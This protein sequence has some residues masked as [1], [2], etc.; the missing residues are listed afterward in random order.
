M[1]SGQFNFISSLPWSHSF[2]YIFITM[3]K[4]INDLKLYYYNQFYDKENDKWNRSG[5]ASGTM[6]FS[7]FLTG[8]NS[9]YRSIIDKIRQTVYHSPEYDELKHKIPYVWCGGTSDTTRTRQ[10]DV[11]EI[12]NI[13][14]IDIDRQDNVKLFDDNGLEVLRYELLHSAPC[15]FYSG[16]SCGGYGLVLYALVK[17]ITINNQHDVFNYFYDKFEKAGIIIDNNASDLVTRLRLI[18]YDPDAEYISD[19][20][21]F[22]CDI[23]STDDV[24]KVENSSKTQIIKNNN[25]TDGQNKE[26]LCID[27]N[28]KLNFKIKVK[29]GEEIKWKDQEISGNAIRWR[30]SVIAD[31]YFGDD[32]KA[33]CDNH[34]YY[35]NNKSIYTKV[36]NL[37]AKPSQQIVNWLIEHNYIK[38]NEDN[39][40]FIKE[41]EYLSNK[42]DIIKSFI[43]EHDKSIIV[44]PTGT[45]KTTLINGQ[46]PSEKYPNGLEGLADL[47]DA[48]VIVPYNNTN[49]LYNR[50]KEISSK[51]KTEFKIKDGK[52]IGKYVM[53][54]DQAVTH[55]HEIKNKNIIIDECH[56]LFS[57]RVFRSRIIQLIDKLNDDF[58]GK[59]TLITATPTGEA[60][61]L[62]INDKLSFYNTR[63]NIN[64]LFKKSVSINEKGKVTESKKSHITPICATIKHHYQSD[65][66]DR[67]VLMDDMSARDVYDALVLRDGI[68]PN[69]ILYYRADR[70]DNEE[71]VKLIKEEMLTKKI[72]IC[73]RIAFNGL[74]FK[75]ENE[76]VLVIT[77]F[78]PG[79]LLSANIIQMVGRVR[80]S[81]VTCLVY[82]ND[83][84]FVSNVEDVDDKLFIKRTQEEYDIKETL[85]SV[86][87]KYT[88]SKWVDI[89]T[90][91]DKYMIEN[92][93]DVDKLISNLIKCNYIQCKKYDDVIETYKTPNYKRK[94]ERNEV[95]DY[96]KN[97]E[98]WNETILDEDWSNTEYARLWQSTYRLLVLNYEKKNIDKIIRIKMM[99]TNSSFENIL[100]LLKLVGSICSMPESEYTDL[101]CKYTEIIEKV[102]HNVDDKYTKSMEEKLE[103]IKSVRK[104]YYLKARDINESISLFMLDEEFKAVEINNKNKESGKIGGQKTKKIRITE[105]MPERNLLKF[106]FDVND[107]F[108]SVNELSELTG[109]SRQTINQ[110]I[111][112]NWICK[113]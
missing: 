112:K 5:K 23:V 41:D 54:I 14:S 75:N 11:T 63:S 73:T 3:K 31:F 17:N 77:S 80:K 59:L 24:D 70:K 67:I 46:N 89:V 82:Y 76:N 29:E 78:T 4:L 57:E 86:S 47:Y 85:Y 91:I 90:K 16:K 9:K 113:A 50:C 58:T 111:S 107:T 49:A 101:L 110:W 13:I 2:K 48:V 39:G 55:W 34:F 69:D 81:N 100:K 74:N 26:L 43:D 68:D 99:R 45:G 64:I 88:D 7:E 1:G 51:Q 103:V 105:E 104:N 96:I 65:K 28:F 18:S 27:R 22:D 83:A 21:P 32:A 37:K 42:I 52:T 53:V 35:E 33:W 71:C 36:S 61:L 19:P 66:F 108:D 106:N 84:D 72:T 40:I 56:V 98:K 109:K 94:I 8:C 60:E 79:S 44:A 6:T 30:L 102:K 10:E 95:R 15:F 92:S 93:L 97:N 25:F 38:N 20:K 62:N 12:Y 87:E